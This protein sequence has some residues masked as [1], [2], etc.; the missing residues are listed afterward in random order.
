[1][2]RACALAL[3]LTLLTAAQPAAGQVKM[4]SELDQLH[5]SVMTLAASRGQFHTDLHDVARLHGGVAAL[6]D[7][8][9]PKRFTCLMD[10]AGLLAATGDLEGA[11]STAALAAAHAQA[12]G[13]FFDAGRAYVTAGLLA[14]RAGDFAAAEGF[15]QRAEWLATL[16]AVDPAESAVIAA[17]LYE[18]QWKI[19]SS[20]PKID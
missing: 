6:R 11:F 1:M 13:D 16:P 18:E 9:D 8:G 14:R 15:R 5:E 2:I 10:Q 4:T 7:A 17:R 20:P 3:T 19:A 12:K